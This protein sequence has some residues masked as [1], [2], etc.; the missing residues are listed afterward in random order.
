MPGWTIGYSELG[1]SAGI[2]RQYEAHL[3][4]QG[5]GQELWSFYD[6][7]QS[8]AWMSDRA[9]RARSFVVS[10]PV[11]AL[12]SFVLTMILTPSEG[13]Q[14]YKDLKS[15]Q[16]KVV[17]A[18]DNRLFCEFV[19]LFVFHFYWGIK[20]SLHKSLTLHKHLIDFNKSFVL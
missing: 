11:R 4:V 9:Y 15:D 14:N 20:M 13:L 12:K 7:S 1:Q 2:D 17:E 16:W 6:T 5:I 18:F 10:M 8:K 19:C 3:E